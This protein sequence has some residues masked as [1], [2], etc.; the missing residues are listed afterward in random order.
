MEQDIWLLFSL[1]FIVYN[2]RNSS[3]HMVYICYYSQL[4][5]CETPLWL[6]FNTYLSSLQEQANNKIHY[7]FIIVSL[8]FWEFTLI[9]IHGSSEHLVDCF[10]S[11]PDS[12]MITLNEFSNIYSEG[13]PSKSVKHFYTNT[14]F[15]QITLLLA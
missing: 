12:V 5:K 6:L 9:S 4:L 3:F 14:T 8:T 10:N 15:I 7:L 13:S 2:I 11:T 1:D